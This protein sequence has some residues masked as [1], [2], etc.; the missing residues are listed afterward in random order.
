MCLAV[1]GLRMSVR[2]PDLSGVPMMAGLVAVS[3]VHDVF[4]MVCCTLPTN[5]YSLLS[6][7]A[8]YF[9]EDGITSQLCVLK[10]PTGV[11]AV[12]AH[13]TGRRACRAPHKYTS[14]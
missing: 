5:Y 1:G 10:G 11:C 2:P 12:A 13:Q 4:R 6:P 8:Y 14:A 3:S 9:L 7:T